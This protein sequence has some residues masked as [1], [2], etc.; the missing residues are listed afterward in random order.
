MSVL[1]KRLLK[2]KHEKLGELQG[3]WKRLKKKAEAI[4]ENENLEHPE[5]VREMKKLYRNANKKEDRKV[6]LVVVNKGNRGKMNRP[7][8]RYKT[9]DRRMK[10]ELRAQKAADKRSGGKRGRGGRAGSGR[11]KR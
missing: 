1:L 4:V 9:V 11:G 6:H 2:Q 7:S 3:A 8:G 10:S 5:K